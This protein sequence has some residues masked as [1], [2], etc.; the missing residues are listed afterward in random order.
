MCTDISVYKY[1]A[2]H[3]ILRDYNIYNNKT[4]GPTP[5]E[6]F[7]ATGKLKKFFFLTRDVRC[8]P[9]SDT[10]HIDTIFKFLPKTRQLGASIFFTAAMIRAFTPARSRGTV[11]TDLLV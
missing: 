9:K 3:N 11:T 5:T 4:N 10:A 2:F 8:V 7:T 6:L 1:R